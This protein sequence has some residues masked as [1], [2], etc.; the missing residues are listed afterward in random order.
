[1]KH[2]RFAAGLC[3]AALLLLLAVPAFAQE[4]AAL[5]EAASD[6]T[7][8]V[9]TDEQQS[10]EQPAAEASAPASEEA[11]AAEAPAVEAAETP[12]EPAAEPA[13]ETPAA[14]P[15]APRQL[16]YVALGDSITAGVGLRDIQYRTATIGLDLEPNFEGYS[17][18]SFVALV[19]NALGMDR[20]HAI[21]LGLPSLM[22]G[23]MLD[24]LRTGGMPK[25][26]QASGAYYV[27]PQYLD[28]LKK[29]DVISVQIGSN[30]ALVPS[31]VAL[32]EATHWK[33]EKLANAM[34]SG[35]LRQF[36]WENLRLL[37]NSISQLTLT[38]QE[39]KN[40]S[41]LLTRGMYDICDTAYANVSANLPQILAELRALN[42]DAQI[43]LMGYTNPVPLLPEWTR[44][45]NRL[46]Q[47]AKDLAS[48]NE[49][50]TYVAIPFTLTAADGHPTV[51]G[52]KYIAKQLLK[53]IH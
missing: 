27:Y 19:G 25:M 53:A 12:A 44:Y 43:L 35:I 15:E 16:T 28:Y 52:H 5:P 20:Q 6:Q 4:P 23:D 7:G 17:S 37:C 9:L 30:D 41:Y 32:G 49:N 36:S 50:V 18:Q 31:I 40:T 42:P 51:A 26:N 11:P 33:S 14:E 3:S 2:P 22:T 45:F 1:M 48:Q 10:A 46:N 13:A 39:T 29:A 34:V 24:I 8:I 38:W 47:L 21:N